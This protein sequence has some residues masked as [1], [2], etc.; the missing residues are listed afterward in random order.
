MASKLGVNGGLLDKIYRTV[1]QKNSTFIMAG[2]VGAFVLERTV[3][4]VCDAVFDKVNEGKQF[5]DIVKKLE[6]K[7]EA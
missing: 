2:L 3:D 6:A 1:V 4:V 5:K 7:N